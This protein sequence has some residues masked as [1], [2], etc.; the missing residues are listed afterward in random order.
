M[1]VPVVCV[2]VCVHVQPHQRIKPY[3]CFSTTFFRAKQKD[4][5]TPTLSCVTKRQIG[6][7]FFS[8]QALPLDHSTTICADTVGSEQH[9]SNTEQVVF[10]TTC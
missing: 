8:L 4:I 6:K 9:T 5:V 1:C 7:F 2:C 10:Q 3:T